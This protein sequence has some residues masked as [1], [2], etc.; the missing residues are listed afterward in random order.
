MRFAFPVAVATLVLLGLPAVGV[1]IADS[2]GYGLDLNTWLEERGGLSHHLALSLPAAFTL[3][4]VPL[5]LII[6][7]LLRLRR[8][9]VAVSSTLLWRASM[10]DLHANALFRWFQRNVP[11]LLQLLAAFLFVYGILGPRLHGTISSGRHYILIIDNSA[12]MSATDVPATRLDWAQSEAL[13]QINAARDDDVGMV[14]AFNRTA[15]IR[16]SYTTDRELLRNAVLG[17]KQSS[18][19]TRL[20]E[21]LRLAAGLSNSTTS[22][23]SAATLPLNTER[24][25]VP[26]EGLAAE[27]HLYSDGGFSPVTDVS[28]ANLTLAYHSPPVPLKPDNIGVIHLVAT[29]DDAGLMNVTATFRNY[30]DTRTDRIAR[31]DVLDIT[32]A[33]RSYTRPLQLNANDTR[34]VEFALPAPDLPLRVTLEGAPDSFTM[35]DVAWFVPSIAR[36]AR[37]AAVGPRNTILDA[38]LDSAETRKITDVTRLTTADITDATKYLD[39]ARN[40]KFD[41]VIFD[42][43]APSTV[44][45]LPR[46]NTLFI[47][48]P[49]PG[50]TTDAVPVKNPRVVGWAGA[51][52]VTRGLRDLYTIPIAEAARFKNLPPGTERLM[53]SDGNVVLLAGVPRPPFT[54]LVLAF[55]IL[56]GAGKWNTLWPLEPSFVLFLR[57][58]TRVYGNIRDGAATEITRPGDA[59]T[60]RS[61]TGKQISLTTPGGRTESIN[62]GSRGEVSFTDTADLGVYTA[63]TGTEPMSFAV[64]LLDAD[65]SNLSPH[66]T[67]SVGS[68]TATSGVVRRS[69]RELWKWAILAALLV[70]LSEWWVYASRVR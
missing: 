17:V 57:N 68:Q 30:R 2:L 23:D 25:D 58:V 64:N 51:H 56:D 40:G 18:G 62:P 28:L 33:V 3:L 52:P 63:T 66:P 55:P 11:L 41:L 34:E 46:A 21:A 69:A 35:D 5:L 10:D 27:V 6:L 44:A 50:L 54:D 24:F 1:L 45:E 9:P 39:P 65:E 26:A 37:I 13:K 38:F 70:L 53:E 15:E 48:S 36:K 31:L 19:Q 32:R 59:V 16:Q 12:S 8:T 14:I 4:A 61:L 7:H 29:Q 49:P 47:G 20:E 42:R 60:L 67:I 22:T 43:C